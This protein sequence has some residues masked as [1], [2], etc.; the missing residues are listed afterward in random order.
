MKDMKT[1]SKL[2]FLLLLMAIGWSC[3]D[4]STIRIP[5]FEKGPNVRIVP[6]PTTTSINFFSDFSQAKIKFDLYSE[7][8]NIQL[9]DIRV[10]R[11]SGTITSAEVSVITF[12]QADIDNNN[13]IIKGVEIALSQVAAVLN[14]PGGLAGLRGADTFTFNNYTTLTNGVTYPSTSTGASLNLSPGIRNSP[15]T[16]SFTL[17]FAA[18]LVCPSNIIEGTYTATQDDAG[19]WFGGPNPLPSTNQV[20]ISKVPGTLNQYLVSDITAGGYFA[21]CGAG[22]F[23][24]N[25]PAI[26]RDVC[27]NISVVTGQGSQITIGQGVS[28]GSWNSAT[29]TLIVHYDD[30]S[31]GSKAAG[32]DLVTRFVKN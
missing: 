11:T 10:S 12:T 28:L 7:S 18:A 26:I 22:G 27:L 9:I 32:F 15:A 3:R 2:F 24:L 5:E 21:C 23:R 6:D 17:N 29:K 25:Q 16:T 8:K 19:I 1:K 31:N 30:V 14:V 20:T 13:G 4:E